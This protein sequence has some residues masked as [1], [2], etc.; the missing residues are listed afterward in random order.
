MQFTNPPTPFSRGFFL[1]NN[2]NN[3]NNSSNSNNNNN[4]NKTTAIKVDALGL[5]TGLLGQWQGLAAAGRQP[6]SRP[7]LKN[8]LFISCGPSGT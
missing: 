3:N 6:A 8:M 5:G 1:H 7:A 2:N 4:R